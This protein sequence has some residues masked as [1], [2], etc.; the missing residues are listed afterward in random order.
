MGSRDVYIGCSE[1]VEDVADVTAA[2][3][4]RVEVP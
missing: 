3:R 2:F 1:I 4:S